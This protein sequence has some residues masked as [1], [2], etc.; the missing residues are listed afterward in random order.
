MI[1]YFKSSSLF[2]LL[3]KYKYRLKRGKRGNVKTTLVDMRNIL[4]NELCIKK[5]DSLIVHC[6]FGSLNANFSP[7]DLIEL[8]R[9]TV[10]ENGHIVMPF[11]P[12][13]LSKHWLDSGR[14]FDP[15]TVIC[16]TGVLAQ[17]FSQSKDVEVSIHPIKAVAVW[18]KNAK[19]ISEGHE[20]CEYPYDAGSPYYKFSQ[21]QNAKS[22]GLGVRNCSLLHMVED[23]FEPKKDYLYSCDKLTGKVKTFS[24]THGIDT[25]YHHGDIPLVQSKDFIDKYCPEVMLITHAHDFVSYSISSENLV[26]KVRVL[27]SKGVNRQCR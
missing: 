25:Y 5:G 13:G 9:Q 15:N 10:G 18:G 1:A 17:V 26:S 24:G 21:L 3:R 8:L 6:G 7:A 4:V 19:Q 23:I 12:P 20:H 11:Y 16:S 22:I 27:F 14:I 2:Q